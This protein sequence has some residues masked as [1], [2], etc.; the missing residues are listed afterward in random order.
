[1][2][3]RPGPAPTSAD[4]IELRGNRAKLS[5]KELEERRANEIKARPLRKGPPAD[6]SPYALEC[7]REL[8]PELEKLGLLSALD[9]PGFRL[10]C[11][12][13]ALARYA[14]EEMRP[15]KADGTVDE[16]TKRREVLERDRVHGQMLKRHPA[17]LIFQAATTE[18]RQWCVEFGLSPSARAS[19]RPAAGG[20]PGSGKERSEADD[21]DAFFGA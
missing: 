8:A 20:R 14:L 12:A 2:P 6:L 18:F 16:R 21:D 10:A 11:E 1:M 19:L 4:V 17:I 3:R 9:S 13:H 5:E 15:K 7:W